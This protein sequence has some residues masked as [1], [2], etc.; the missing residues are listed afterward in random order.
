MTKVYVVSNYLLRS[1]TLM[2][3]GN[4]V[5]YQWKNLVDTVV[6]TEQSWKGNKLTH[7]SLRGPDNA[8]IVWS[9]SQTSINWSCPRKHQIQANEGKLQYSRTSFIQ[10]PSVPQ[11]G[12]QQLFPF[13]SL[14]ETNRYGSEVSPRSWKQWPTKDIIGSANDLC[15]WIPFVNFKCADFN[16]YVLAMYS[17]VP[18]LSKYTI[19]PSE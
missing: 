7:V 10:R 17:H 12:G 14:K 8:L 15:M 5:V 6:T 2:R 1:N 3:K 18:V 9:R 4:I 11:T 19:K 16:N 13:G